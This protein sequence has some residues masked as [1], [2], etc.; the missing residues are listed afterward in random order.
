MAES[1]KRDERGDPHSDASRENPFR[2]APEGVRGSVPS[3]HLAAA[4]S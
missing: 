2:Q 3:D 4:E 1:G